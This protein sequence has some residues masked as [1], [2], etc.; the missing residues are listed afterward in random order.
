MS[1]RGSRS[2]RWRS[3][4][5][6]KTLTSVANMSSAEVRIRIEVVNLEILVA[7]KS[8]EVGLQALF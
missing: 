1:K 6:D 2:T 3:E 5:N 7:A 4:L 8:G